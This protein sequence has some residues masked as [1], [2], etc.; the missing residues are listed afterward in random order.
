M[1]RNMLA[2]RKF[3]ATTLAVFAALYVVAL[4]PPIGC[5]H[6]AA[7][8]NVA[9]HSAEL[10]ECRAIGKDAGRYDVYTACANKVDAKYGVSP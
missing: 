6:A 1:K 7:G 8:L 9:G 2:V 4:A 5:S 10:A 3:F